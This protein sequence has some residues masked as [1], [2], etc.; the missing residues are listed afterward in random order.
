MEYF[1]ISVNYR[2]LDGDSGA[3]P[4]QQQHMLVLTLEPRE[5][6]LQSSPPPLTSVPP[7]A[8]TPGEGAEH[9][10]LASEHPGSRRRGRPLVGFGDC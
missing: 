8:E 7:T 3:H 1:T 4:G 5:S 10:P 6:G 2:P 9:P